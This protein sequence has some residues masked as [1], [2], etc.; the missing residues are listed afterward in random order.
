MKRPKFSGVMTLLTSF[1]I[2]GMMAIL[3]GH[4]LTSCIPNRKPKT[5]TPIFIPDN[6]ASLE[7][8]VETT[9]PEDSPTKPSTNLFHNSSLETDRKIAEIKE[10]QKYLINSYSTIPA[11]SQSIIYFNYL[12]TLFNEA[13]TLD[14]NSNTHFGNET[15]MT[16]GK[17]RTTCTLK[18]NPKENTLGDLTISMK[19]HT[20]NLMNSSKKDDLPYEVCF[21]TTNEK[22]PHGIIPTLVMRYKPALNSKGNLIWDP[23]R[24]IPES[25]VEYVSEGQI[26]DKENA[27]P[28]YT[29]RTSNTYWDDSKIQGD[30]TVKASPGSKFSKTQDLEERA[31]LFPGEDKINLDFGACALRKQAS[32]LFNHYLQYHGQSPVNN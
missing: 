18:L 22:F 25:F 1:T 20:D 17:N 2:A 3:A 30:I 12:T 15:Q 6:S 26:L 14:P 9:P 21:Q 16:I 27:Q 28:I 29:L 31:F 13:L 19:Y 11:L 8:L 23:F 5:P 32:Y 10:Y 24:N 7:N 4:L